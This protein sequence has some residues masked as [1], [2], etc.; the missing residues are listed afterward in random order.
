MKKSQLTNRKIQIIIILV[1]YNVILLI[2]SQYVLKLYVLGSS[3]T[4]SLV[5]VDYLVL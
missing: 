4:D 3:L 5:D 2:L 1:Y